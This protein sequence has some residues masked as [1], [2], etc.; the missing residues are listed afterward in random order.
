MP[1][2]SPDVSRRTATT[3][4]RRDFV[5]T[6]AATALA[7]GIAVA[8]AG[9]APVARTPATPSTMPATPA[10]ASPFARVALVRTTDRDDGLRRLLT[11]TAPLAVQGKHIVIKPNFNSA[12]PAPGSTHPVIL[13]RMVET[14]RAGGAQAITVADRSGMGDTRRVMAQLGIDALAAELG[15]ALVALD[16]VGAE[17]WEL[18]DA[19]GSHW[20]QG[21]PFPKLIREADA[22]VQLCCLKTHRFG[23][24]FTLSLKNTIGLV[25][26]TLPGE[27]YN[28]MNELHGSPHQRV[29]IAETN[30]AY[31]PALVIMD[32]VTAFVAGGPDRG[33][34]V[35]AEVMLAST[36]R[37]AIDAVGVALLRHFGARSPVSDGAI[38][39]QEQIARAA[40]LGLG[41][42]AADQ[43]ELISDDAGGEALI[44]SV[45]NQLAG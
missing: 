14:L 24:H 16:E 23:G 6:T 40:A 13:R 28:Y 33:E 31:A 2:P 7:G 3:L 44:N 36:D 21:F 27:G 37:V 42:S 25:A 26:K 4:S 20:R 38:F 1:A 22:V 10:A 29:L 18:V 8:L 34:E 17:A 43:I 35:A 12:D 11:L 5:Q 19:P 41:V 39:A 45:R 32:G 30:V 9:C 15:F